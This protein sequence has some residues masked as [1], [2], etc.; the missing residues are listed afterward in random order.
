MGVFRRSPK[1]I[2]CFQRLQV[3]NNWLRV[4]NPVRLKVQ[5]AENL[6]HRRPAITFIIIECAPSC[7]TVSWPFVIVIVIVFLFTVLVIHFDVLNCKCRAF[8]IF[9]FPAYVIE[10]TLARTIERLSAQRAARARLGDV[11]IS[12][13]YI[14]YHNRPRAQITLSSNRRN[15]LEN[16]SNWFNLYS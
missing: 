1:T 7:L 15:L 2:K 13:N 5:T 8:F 14:N 4:R 16:Y 9:Y 6:P 11:M 12:I 3:T 10:L